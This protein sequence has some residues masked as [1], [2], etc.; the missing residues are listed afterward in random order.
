MTVVNGGYLLIRDLDTSIPSRHYYSGVPVVGGS[1]FILDV[2]PPVHCSLPPSSTPCIVGQALLDVGP[3]LTDSAL[4]QV[5][6][7]GWLD[8]PAGI[9]S[10]TLTVYTMTETEGVLRETLPPVATAIFNSTDEFLYEYPLNVTEGAYSVVMRVLD[11]AGNSR[12]TRRLLLVDSSSEL[13]VDNGTSLRVD[14]AVPE[15][16]FLWLNSTTTPVVVSGR[17]HFYN[18]HLRTRDL[19][20]PVANFTPAIE[21]EYDHPLESGLYPRQGTRNALGVTEMRYSVIIDQVG[22]ASEDGPAQ[23]GIFPLSTDD[24]GLQ[25]A[26]LE[27]G[28]LD[29]GDSIRIWFQAS[30]YAGHSAVDWVLFHVDSSAPELDRLWLV[31]NGVGELALHGTESLLD[32]TITFQT[33]D[34]HSG[35]QS[36]EYWIGTETS[37][38][39]WGQIPVQDVGR[40]NCTS[41]LSLCVCD[42]LHHCSLTHYTLTPSPSHFTSSHITLHDTEYY[43]VVTATNH[44]LLTSSLTHTFTTDTTPPL[45]GVVMDAVLGSHDLDHTHNLSLSAWWADFFDRETSILVFQ[46]HFGTKCLNSSQFSYPLS[47]GDVVMETTESWATWTAPGPGTYHVTVVTYNH[48]LQPSS[49]A[50]SDGITVDLSP[51]VIS[52]VIIPGTVETDEVTYISTDHLLNVSWTASDNVGIRDYHIATLSDQAMSQGQ[53]TN[54]TFVGR[55]SFFSLADSDLLSNGNTFYIVVKVTDLALHETEATFGPV[56]VDITPPVTNGNLTVERSGDHM[57]VTWYNDTFTDEQS[58]ID[59]LEYSIGIYTPPPP[60][61]PPHTHTSFMCLFNC[62]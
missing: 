4:L 40:E 22:G 27:V 51:P 61:P 20:A 54:F 13:V 59:S 41:A 16:G 28:G 25:G 1:I 15:T 37:D 47:E 34:P 12:Y 56:T 44:A 14:T 8:E 49:P 48:A 53:S 57:I 7:G 46:Y 43:I 32:L 35:I 24:L 18:T 29:D 3:G 9:H 19:L 6:W 55:Q 42:S 50:C 33:S 5:L 31:W 62:R 58:G 60:L 52:E 23:P 30:D 38:V 36:L 2:V 45:P 10:Y 21:T 26:H 17:G 11:L 39:A